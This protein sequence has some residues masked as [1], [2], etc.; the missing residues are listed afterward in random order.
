MKTSNGIKQKNKGRK[1]GGFTLVEVLVAIFIFSLAI[2]ALMA[3]LASGIS[4]T[5]Y[6]KQKMTATYLAQ[7]GIE[8]MRNMRDDY[9]L[10]PTTSFNWGKSGDIYDFMKAINLCETTS[11]PYGC[12]FD[13]SILPTDPDFIISPC[14]V[15]TN[16]G[17][18][19]ICELYV[20]NGNYNIK[21]TGGINSGFLRT[22]TVDPN[23]NSGQEVKMTSTVFWAEGTAT[24]NVSF[25]ENLFNWTQPP[26]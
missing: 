2:T 20:N 12:G 6:A 26:S 8:Y 4:D 10:Y 16:F 21:Y 17:S 3:A 14:D 11:S 19:N 7:E 15:T 25:S 13:S 9:V 23:F 1:S 5:T 18:S 22:I 24:H